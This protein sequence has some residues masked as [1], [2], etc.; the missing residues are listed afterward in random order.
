MR[1]V[2]ALSLLTL[3]AGCYRDIKAEAHYV[4]SDI[5]HKKAKRAAR[6]GHFGKA[7]KEEYKSER[8]EAKGDYER[9]R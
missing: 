9:S 3:G 8:E 5:H 4:K 1:M 2:I 6:H 7:A